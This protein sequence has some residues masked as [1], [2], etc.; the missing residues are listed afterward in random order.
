MNRSFRTLCAALSSLTLALP[1][2]APA[3]P[4]P[5]STV[6]H[7]V[8]RVGDDVVTSVEL[9]RVLAPVIRQLNS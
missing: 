1:H 3:A 7:A 2:H 5:D 9:D 8:A 4:T 6:S